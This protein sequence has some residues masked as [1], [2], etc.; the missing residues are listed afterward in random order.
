MSQCGDRKADLKG[1]FAL[2]MHLVERGGLSPFSFP[3]MKLFTTLI[4]ALTFSTPGL[5]SAQDTWKAD[6]AHSRL[7]FSIPHLGINEVTGL[8]KSFD[9]AVTTTR[10]DFSDAQFVLTV[11][12]ASI[13]T[14][15]EKRDNH[16]RSADFFEVSKY[17]KMTFKS[18]SLKPNGKDRYKLSGDLTLHGTTRPVVMDLWF[19]GTTTNQDKQVA[20]FQ[21]TG[22]LKRSEYGIGP[23]FPPPAIGDEV[24]IKADGEFIKQ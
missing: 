23:K 16:L 3:A 7:A 13:D 20:G 4:L 22:T 8:F 2:A 15:V 19:R 10:P 11:D 21:L 14:E 24:T 17:P 18:S 9:V 6:P 5:V 12:T 1:R